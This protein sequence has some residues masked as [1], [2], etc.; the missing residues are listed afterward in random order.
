VSISDDDVTLLMAVASLSAVCG[1][2]NLA[3]L[4]FRKSV[5]RRVSESIHINGNWNIARTLADRTNG[6][7]EL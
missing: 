2:E 5:N 1:C 4:S 3:P 6:H 7:H